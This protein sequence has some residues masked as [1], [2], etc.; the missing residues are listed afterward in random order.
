MNVEVQDS[1]LPEKVLHIVWK[2]RIIDKIRELSDDEYSWIVDDN[3]GIVD[4]N[5]LFRR[6]IRNPNN[7]I[8]LM[9][10]MDKNVTRCWSKY[11]VKLE[12]EYLDFTQDDLDDY[13]SSS[14][15]VL[16]RAKQDL[17]YLDSIIDMIRNE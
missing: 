12:H 3:D 10:D 2:D 11:P 13:K 6:A 7:Q 4:D 14:L 9:I 15:K 5:I 16:E 1:T 17:Q 8:V